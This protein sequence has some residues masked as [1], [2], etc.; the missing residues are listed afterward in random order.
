M[1]LLRTRW[2]KVVEQQDFYFDTGRIEKFDRRLSELGVL[3]DDR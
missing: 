3:P 2:G 1:L